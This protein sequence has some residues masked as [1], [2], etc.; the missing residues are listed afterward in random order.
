MKALKK[1]IGVCV[2]LGLLAISGWYCLAG[3]H[4][5]A[6]GVAWAIIVVAFLLWSALAIFQGRAKEWD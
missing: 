4:Y 5:D 1:T 6:L 2:T 3:N